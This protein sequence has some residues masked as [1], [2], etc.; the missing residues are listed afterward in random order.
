[1]SKYHYVQ[2]NGG[3]EKWKLILS[4]QKQRILTSDDPPTLITVLSVSERVDEGM[5]RE[6]LENLKYH[7]PFYLDFDGPDIDVVTRQALKLL[8]RLEDEMDV[9]MNSLS[10]FASGGK[11]FHVEVPMETFLTKVPKE[12]IQFLPH[13]YREMAY[14][15]FVDT[16]DLRVYTARKGR[17]WRVPNK[18]RDNGRY[19]VPI[20]WEEMRRMDAELYVD[21]T[22]RKRPHMTAP[23]APRASA[24]LMAQYDKAVA[25]IQK[26]AKVRRKHVDGKLAKDWAG[27]KDGVAPSIAALLNGDGLRDT[28]GWNDISM[29]L[30]ILATELSWKEEDLIAR[31]AAL[32]E[33]HVGERYRTAAKREE[34]LRFMWHYMNDNP[35]YTFGAAPLK[36]LMAIATPDLDGLLDE[37]VEAEVQQSVKAHEKRAQERAEAGEEREAAEAAPPPPEDRI[38]KNV[39]IR[40]SGIY[41]KKEDEWEPICQMSFRDVILL[42]DLDNPGEAIGFEA[43]ILADGAFK[44]R[45]IIPRETFT[46]KQ[47][48][49]AFSTRYLTPMVGTEQHVG[50]VMRRLKAEAE[51]NSGGVF[52]TTNREGLDLVN[53]PHASAKELSEPFPIWASPHGVSV[54]EKTKALGVN[55]KF[56]GYPH[57][58][59]L[60]RSDLM[61]APDIDELKGDPN[62]LEVIRALLTCQ[63]PEVISR[64]IGWFT[65]ANFR[66]YFHVGYEE[67][68]LLHVNGPAGAGKTAMTHLLMSLHYFR[69]EVKALTPSATKH[70]F[71]EYMS[72]S[73]SIP[74]ILDE[75]KPHEMS[76][77]MADYLRGLLRAAWNAQQHS[78]GGG[79]DG[80]P[81]VRTLNEKKFSAPVVYIAEAL[82]TESATAE[83]SVAVTVAKPPLSTYA[84]WF[85]RFNFVRDNSEVISALGRRITEWAYQQDLADVKASYDPIRNRVLAEMG[86]GAV[87]ADGKPLAQRLNARPVHAYSVTYWGLKAFRHVVED[88]F[89]AGALKAEFDRLDES[90]WTRVQEAQSA[91][92]AEADKVLS[93]LTFMSNERDVPDMCAIRRGVEYVFTKLGERDAVH[94]SMRSA[95]LRYSQYCRQ[96]G[97]RPL[98]PSE[99]AFLHAMQSHNALLSTDSD[100]IPGVR[101]VYVFDCEQLERNG[102]GSFK[103]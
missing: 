72:A 60:Y 33:K 31:A 103:N 80:S 13:I 38:A 84:E 16:L 48:F 93:M 83:R 23:E 43:D 59:G 91:V 67:F 70:A 92:M 26:H 19:K 24:E 28:A 3:E 25:K 42:A 34:R 66:M 37:A 47:S 89:G 1:M 51:A 82:V 57:E 49:H 11:G 71:R 76:N 69:E 65:A 81:D 50:A 29:Q 55:L 101:T 5:S 15:I 75:Y 79:K 32:T 86:P 78:A 7:G 17:M 102:V 6:D 52:Y 2:Q 88:V 20:T 18:L 14:S 87:D 74:F 85:R 21:L 27:F 73:A 44:E 62:T 95:Y 36:A 64:L 97:E 96:R 63:Q 46:T 12:G 98:Y 58:H 94:L 35:C 54:P 8:R 53:I 100:A 39:E 4:D 99:V 45:R 10:I 41:A 22:S 61:N 30:A 90:F 9:N 56:K 68:P 40:P 77:D